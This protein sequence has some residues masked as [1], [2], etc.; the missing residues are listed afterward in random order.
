MMDTMEQVT[1]DT[2]ARDRDTLMERLLEAAVGTFNI[3]AVHIGSQLGFY[4]KL[5][6]G[7]L[8]ASD[9][10]KHRHACPLRP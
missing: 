9:L 8:T 7:P 10:A 6:A 2:A 5:A 1:T 3:Y 4:L